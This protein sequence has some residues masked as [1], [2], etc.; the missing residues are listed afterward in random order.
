MVRIGAAWAYRQYLRDENL[1]AIQAL[2]KTEKRGLW[3]L[4]EA[5]NM[6]PW[7]WRRNCGN[8]VPSATP[9]ECQSKGNI[10]SKGDR[11]YHVPG[12]RHYSQTRINESRGE[13]WFCS[14][15]EARAAGWRAPSN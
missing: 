1:L 2:A 8:P 7:E 14:D 6:P 11:I 12:S 9:G 15:A 4:S 5:Q 10:N 3:G 13:W